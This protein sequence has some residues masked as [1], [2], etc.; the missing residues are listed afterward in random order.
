MDS[1][2][3]RTQIGNS[4][5]VT[6]PSSP[7]AVPSAGADSRRGV[8]SVISHLDYTGIQHAVDTATEYFTALQEKENTSTNKPGAYRVDI[9]GRHRPIQ[10]KI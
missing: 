2:N 4:N 8:R 3:A 6:P 5:H 7:A 10:K 9:S 1:L